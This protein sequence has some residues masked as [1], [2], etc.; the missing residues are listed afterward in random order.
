MQSSFLNQNPKSN[1]ENFPDAYMISLFRSLVKSFFLLRSEPEQEQQ[2]TLV[3]HHTSGAG[4]TH[5]LYSFSE[6]FFFT[7]FHSLAFFQFNYF[8]YCSW[9]CIIPF[10][11]TY[12]YDLRI[13][14]VR[15][16]VQ[17]VQY[18]LDYIIAIRLFGR[19][20]STRQ[21]FRL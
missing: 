20:Y 3:D 2:N 12:L 8:N 13:I 5:F 15:N 21:H 11:N 10:P 18:S 4:A 17:C 6:Y 16:A 14:I 1:S 9:V 19:T 7:P